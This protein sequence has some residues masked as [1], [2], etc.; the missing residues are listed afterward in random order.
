[1]TFRPG[2]S[3]CYTENEIHQVETLSK[4]DSFHH[5]HWLFVL[6]IEIAIRFVNQNIIINSFLVV[7]QR[8]LTVKGRRFAYYRQ[9]QTKLPWRICF[10]TICDKQM[11]ASRLYL[12]LCT[13][14]HA[15]YNK[16]TSL[17]R[18]RCQWQVWTAFHSLSGGHQFVGIFTVGPYRE[19]TCNVITET[20]PRIQ[21]EIFI[22]QFFII[23]RVFFIQLMRSKCK[24]CVE[25]MLN[26]KT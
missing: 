8:L 16:L 10:V 13:G 18:R 21:V 17:F 20:L 19:Q 1:M 12:V 7:A 14:S 5:Q 15:A 4:Y 24:H 2:H 22:R 23:R 6:L 26:I 3:A 25:T 9:Y 11:T